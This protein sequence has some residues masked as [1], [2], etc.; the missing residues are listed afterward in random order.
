VSYLDFSYNLD[1]QQLSSFHIANFGDHFRPH[2][3]LCV[4]YF[5]YRLTCLSLHMNLFFLHSCSWVFLKFLNII[6]NYVWWIMCVCMIINTW[7]MQYMQKISIIWVYIVC[8]LIFL[9]YFHCH[10]ICDLALES[11]MRYNSQIQWIQ[12]KIVVTLKECTTFMW[13][14][15]LKLDEEVSRHARLAQRHGFG[16]PSIFA[17]LVCWGW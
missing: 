17:Q 10:S 1:W 8:D 9:K 7:N 11:W 4:R 14:C 2:M 15:T 12:W 16:L 5:N 6:F 3:G 13:A